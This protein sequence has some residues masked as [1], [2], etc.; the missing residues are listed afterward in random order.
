MRLATYSSEVYCY[1]IR[2]E[3]PVT[4]TII[5]PLQAHVG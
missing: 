3:N 1:D 4:E 5:L 2:M